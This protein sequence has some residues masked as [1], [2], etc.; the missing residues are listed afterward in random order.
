MSERWL[1]SLPWYDLPEMRALTDAFWAYLREQLLPYFV[2]LPTTLERQTPFLEQW[3]SPALLFSQACSYDVVFRFEN[4]LQVILTPIYRVEGLAPG[5]YRSHVVVRADL[6]STGLSELRGLRAVI[7]DEY[8]HSGMNVLRALIAPHWRVQQTA[9]FSEVFASGGHRLSLE[10]LQ[11]ERADVC[12]IDA[13]TWA[14]LERHAPDA[15][16]GLRILC[17]SPWQTPACPYIT[18]AQRSAPEI[19]ALQQALRSFCADPATAELREELL[20]GGVCQKTLEDYAVIRQL[21]HSNADYTE[22]C[23]T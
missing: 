1:A 7:N 13:V 15:L 4:S 21:A 8:S 16:E 23:Q 2:D 10:A 5:S 12:A 3:Q 22:L 14:L 6:K 9:F 20:L 19:Q 17:S 11:A 18:S